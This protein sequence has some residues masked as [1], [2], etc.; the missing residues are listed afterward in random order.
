MVAFFIAMSQPR[1]ALIAPPPEVDIDLPATRPPAPRLDDQG[2]AIIDP[3]WIVRPTIQYPDQAARQ[4]V[5]GGEA[6]I[7]RQV[8]IEGRISSCDVVREAP[9]DAGF[10]EA[11]VAVALKARLHPQQIDG[12]AHETRIRYTARF[13]R[14]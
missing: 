14:E 5:E 11:A 1:I 13:R 9:A 4:G 7:D 10:G 2:R 6:V 3:V 12:E 8:T